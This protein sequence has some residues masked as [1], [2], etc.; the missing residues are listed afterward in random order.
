MVVA[1]GTLGERKNRRCLNAF[2]NSEAGEKLPPAFKV[3]DEGSGRGAGFFDCL[4][5]AAQLLCER[6]AYIPAQYVRRRSFVP[7]FDEGAQ[8]VVVISIDKRVAAPAD[9]LRVREL[10]A[11][12]DGEDFLGNDLTLKDYVVEIVSECVDLMF[13]EVADHGYCATDIAI[14]GG[15][16]DGHFCF[17][18]VAAE[19][20]AEGSGG[21][22]DKTGAAVTRL[23]IFL[24]QTAELQAELFACVQVG[25]GRAL[26]LRNGVLV[27]FGDGHNGVVRAECLRQPCCQIA[28]SVRVVA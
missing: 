23:N 9:G 27:A 25:D 22:S 18:G 26:E 3:S 4:L 28:R 11:G 14:E 17:V 12:A 1:E 8:Q 20:A 21:C 19:G 15:V 13:P 7:V 2:G 24:D 16:A 10:G 5:R 6:A